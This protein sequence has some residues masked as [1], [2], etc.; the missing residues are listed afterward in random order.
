MANS[1]MDELVAVLDVGK[2]LLS[3]ETTLDDLGEELCGGEPANDDGKAPATSPAAG[4][5]KEFEQ[6]RAL[7]TVTPIRR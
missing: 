7:A 1:I 6:A 5:G 3:G 4:E 2:K